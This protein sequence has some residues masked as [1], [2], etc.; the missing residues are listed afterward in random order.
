MNFTVSMLF[1][2]KYFIYLFIDLYIFYIYIFF[3]L[4][5]ARTALYKMMLDLNSIIAYYL[6]LS[7]R[8]LAV[9]RYAQRSSLFVD[10]VFDFLLVLPFKLRT[11]C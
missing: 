10:F 4:I 2:L 11:I 1:S 6:Y 7:L 9:L 8:L 3:I 5:I